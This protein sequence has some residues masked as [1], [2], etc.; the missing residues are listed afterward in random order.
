MRGKWEYD[1]VVRRLIPAPVAAF[2]VVVVSAALSVAAFGQIHGTPTSVTSIG[3]GG[4]YDRPPGVRASVTS[5]GPNGFND[6]HKQFNCCI[7]PLFP[8]NRNPQQ[9]GIHHHHRRNSFFP[10]GGAVYAVPYTPVYILDPGE[11]DSMEEPAAAPQPAYPAGPTIFDRRASGESSQALE[12]AY[13]D[14]LRQESSATAAA[15]AAAPAEPAPAAPAAEPPQDG[16]Q[17]LLVFKDGHQLEINNYAIVGATLYDMTPGH[18]SRVALAELDLD[19]T[20]KQNNDRGVDFKLP[21]GPAA[22]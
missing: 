16:P 10:L 1:S 19:A 22:R 8:V 21:P 15:P 6:P 20:V 2:A 5:L 17:T 12:A 3:F 9:F 7:N 13:A 11:D 18:R 4:H 14:R